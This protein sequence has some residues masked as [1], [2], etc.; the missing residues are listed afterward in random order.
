ML[1]AGGVLKS[2]SLIVGHKNP[3][4]TTKRHRHSSTRLREV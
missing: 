4:M 2:I 3:A 1:E